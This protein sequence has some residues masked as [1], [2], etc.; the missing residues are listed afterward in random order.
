M[1]KSVD[2]EGRSFI[3]AVNHGHKSRVKNEVKIY[4]AKCS[5]DSMKRFVQQFFYSRFQKNVSISVE[6]IKSKSNFFP[7]LKVI[8]NMQTIYRTIKL[9]DRWDYLWKG[10][11]Q[12]HDEYK[13]KIPFPTMQIYTAKVYCIVNQLYIITAISWSPI[14]R[15]WFYIMAIE[16]PN[17][18]IMHKDSLIPNPRMEPNPQCK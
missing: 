14:F 18:Q 12:D 8:P 2:G 10:I 17:V 9:L 4:N 3:I 11:C 7:N 16:V 5:I 1:Q 6:W 15:Q 13:H